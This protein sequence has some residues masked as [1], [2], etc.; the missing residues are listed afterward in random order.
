MNK[1]LLTGM[2][3][4][5]VAA[6][7]A[8]ADGSVVFNEIMYQPAVTNEA[9]MEWVELHNQMT[10]DVDLSGWA[11]AEGV[12]FLFPSG[13]V[14]RGGG[15]LVI[16]S[17]P[18]TLM[19][20][21]GLTNVLGP[22]S[23]RL[24]N[25]GE[26]I[27]LR[28]NSGRL[29]DEVNYGDNSPW[30]VGPD[31][32]GPSLAKLDP[33]MGSAAAGNWAASAQVG[34]TPG[35][36]NFGAAA[37]TL[38]ALVTGSS[39]A[40][41]FVPRNESLGR[42][43]TARNFDDAAWSNVVAAIGFDLGSGAVYADEVMADAPAGY[44]RLNETNG[45]VALDSSGNGRHG[46]YLGG[47]TL[48]L[49]GAV[50]G[51]GR[52]T[53]FDGSSGYVQLP[54]T[55]GGTAETTVEAWVNL[56]DPLTGDFESIIATPDGGFTHFQLY[57]A[58]NAGAYTPEGFV[59]LPIP[60]PT[61]T[62]VWRHIAMV[63]KSGDS[64]IYVDGA[65]FGSTVGTTFSSINPA[66]YTPGGTRGVRLANGYAGG[67]WLRGRL[68]QAA[69][70]NH[71]LTP[72]RIQ[73]HSLAGMQGSLTNLIGADLGAQM[74]GQ[75]SS[76]YL[77]IPFRIDSPELV[78]TLKLRVKYDDGLVV[79]LNGEPVASRNAPANPVFDSV[80]L[81]NRAGVASQIAEEISLTPSTP[82]LVQGTNILALHALNSSATNTDLLL[83][84][85][86]L[87][88]QRDAVFTLALNEVSASTD[89][90]FR[91]ELV[92]TGAASLDVGGY[93][94]GQSGGA[95]RFTMPAQTLAPGEHLLWSEGQTGIRGGNG[96]KIFLY[97]PGG[98][99]LVDAVVVRD[100]AR[101]RSPDGTGGWLN[102]AATTFG[103]TNAVSLHDEVVINE[104]MYHHQPVWDRPAAY[105][106]SVVLPID[107]TW[108]YS[109]QGIDYGAAWRQP[110]YDD[111]A[112]R[113]GAAL[114]YVST[115][116]LP[117]PKNTPLTLGR[118]T[119]YFRAQFVFNGDT[120]GTIFT[121]NPVIDDG[122]VFY[123]NGVEVLR[124]N[125]PA[126][127]VTYAMFASST[128]GTAAYT[129]PYAISPTNLVAGTNTL[130]VEVHQAAS[131]DPDVVFG[132]ELRARV[133][134]TPAT[135]FAESGEE[136]IELYNRSSAAVDLTGWQFDQG[137]QFRFPDG[138]TLAPG[139]FLVVAKEP[140]A[141][142]AQWPGL[143]VAGPF[144]NQLSN[145]GEEIVLQDA[146]G[147]PADVV[148]YLDG[149]AWPSQADGGGSSLE[150]R[151]PRADNGQG[152]A[153][154]ASDESGKTSWRRYTYRGY[155]A[156]SLGPDTQWREFV[157]GLIDDG[158]VLL[159]DL[160][161]VEDPD[162]TA[163]QMLSNTSFDSGLSGWRLVGNH[164]GEVVPDPENP[165]NPVLHLTAH[166]PAEH[167]SNH[168]ET[169]LAGGRSVVNGRLYEISYRARWVAGCPRLN[170]RLYFN[171]LPHTMLIDPPDH[172][173]TPGAPNS[174]FAANIG[175]T[176]SGL[177]HT[178]SVPAP[179]E[180]VT[181]SVKATDP[182]GVGALTLFWRVSE[183]AWSNALMTLSGSDYTASLP[184]Q[185]AAAVTQFYISAADALGAVSCSPATG[186]D[187]RALCQVS[188]GQAN[189]ALA[190][191]LRVIM[192]PSEARA[193]HANSNL[194]SN[195]Q[196]GCTVIYDEDEVC[197]DCG[198]R[199][200]GTTYSRPY[201]QFVS[202][203]LYF[204]PEHLFRGAHAS[205][206]VDRSGRGLVGSPGQD[207]ILIKHLLQRAG[208]PCEEADL[209]RF[210]APLPQ[211]TSS[212]MLY[213]GH[214]TGDYLDSAYPAGGGS[215]LFEL[216]GAY[217]P[218]RTADGNPESPKV[219]EA[220]PIS[221]TDI[222]N[223][224]DDP[225]GYRWN[226]MPHQ[227]QARDD[228]SRIVATAKAFDLT[229]PALETTTAALIDT[230]EWMR[231]YAALSLCGVADAY[232]M[233]N[234][235]NLWLY[236]RP[237]DGRVLALPHD[238]DV[239][240]SRSG[241]GA[242]DR[243]Q[244]KPAQNHQ[245]ARQPAAI[246]LAPARSDYEH[247]EP[248]L[249]GPWADHY[250]NFLPGQ[251]FSGIV[252]YITQRGNYVLSQLPATVPFA[253]TTRNGADF[254]TNQTSV[255]LAGS[256]PIEVQ[257]IVLVGAAAQPVFRW[258]TPTN[259]QVTL[260]LILGANPFAF[261]AVDYQNNPVGTKQITVT[262]TVTG[263][264][265]DTDGDGMPDAW[266]SANG[267]LPDTPDANLDN[268][269]DGLLNYQ[270]FLAGT[271]PL[272][273]ES[274]LRLEIGRSE[275]GL[276]RVSFTAVAG[277]SYS[278]LWRDEADAGVWTRAADVDPAITSRLFQTN[279]A[280]PA[281][282]AQRFYRITTP[283]QP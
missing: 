62:A 17:S 119:Y 163:V 47:V 158:E 25:G 276:L 83:V 91:V 117:A 120:N 279:W 43:W 3:I 277:R 52:A 193:L 172:N 246:L 253:I 103:G 155:A 226:F 153:W 121:L 138:T 259:W 249:M 220:G 99:T 104:I 169:T 274:V 236:V 113:Q 63:M 11:L 142:L 235:H 166:G 124:E 160:S 173:G 251:N 59:A 239:C 208:L 245:P 200:R 140:A 222:R 203:S 41:V 67:R 152:A 178:P 269:G 151:D 181:V 179:G 188:D 56:D 262:T 228:Y 110:T 126:G 223:L 106:E 123:L 206:D 175:P 23:G 26:R 44:W 258:L 280:W 5:L 180:P 60:P 272:D 243:R 112:W 134:A 66:T 49:A 8:L 79:Y 230:S 137:I 28:N 1:P 227:G 156:A 6:R 145:A 51:D 190:H 241:H 76:A 261:T 141:L 82:L 7:A 2:L 271:L 281:G 116:A 9:A 125:M 24:S 267:L 72:D 129:G 270:E 143:A 96:D 213:L 168:A 164:H 162:G 37:S 185:P 264:G 191:N 87:V 75:S 133:Q 48:G 217:Y 115:A 108:R 237:T 34:G 84:P 36:H 22:F 40:R 39:P 45:S 69:I 18:A 154:A 219:A 278:V 89:A 216:D 131:G 171:R 282:A 46:T 210:I 122:A 147:N 70:Y 211:H 54:G 64:R 128:V 225:E 58:G 74:L 218:T 19:A 12:L 192:L 247:L 273:T 149:G 194:M 197:Y 136:W 250:D 85:E 221:Y 202:F 234:P 77:R 118:R 21:S 189:L 100:C 159:D 144:T 29:M 148:H 78:D 98:G 20:A 35:A 15:H 263:G 265:Q 184:G 170:T 232:T 132:V 244:R 150:L 229:G 283:K 10:I 266:E 88:H 65:Q 248:R 165:G 254:L 196:L 109:Q 212:A 127:N 139:G 214:F 90:V 92:N 240:Y 53:S 68:S 233:G 174:R 252:D 275:D 13:T 201:D 146:Q 268:D 224:G 71:A 93:I 242:A 209:I 32:G 255:T 204:P 260:P 215:M 81:T 167:F 73:A 176:C 199:L 256:A 33:R 30:P 38:T 97:A 183:G 80:A 107:A 42:T 50:P 4:C 195:D 198:V 207:E 114:L 187:S 102:A 61:P 161:V 238:W 31:G 257:R 182:D 86:L 157:L 101:A 14:I 205:V 130:A 111:S 177:R 186:P 57:T 27:E 94:L 16:A 105:Q 55:W 95:A 135:V 231:M